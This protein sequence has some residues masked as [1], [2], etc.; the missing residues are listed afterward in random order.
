[1][2]RFE[3]ATF[4]SA[5]SYANH[6]ATQTC[7]MIEIKK[8]K[9][10]SF[11]IKPIIFQVQ[12]L[13]SIHCI[14]ENT[15]HRTVTYSSVVAGWKASQKDAGSNLFRFLLLFFYFILEGYWF[16]SSEHSKSLNSVNTN[17]KILHLSALLQFYNL[18]K[19]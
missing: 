11:R 19:N 3:P 10:N 4:T 2:W 17:K 7:Y 9:Q 1:M 16:K 14:A 6:S 15:V 5:V 8:Q 12:S 18:T 13:G